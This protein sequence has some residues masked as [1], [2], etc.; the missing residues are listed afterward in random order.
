MMHTRTFSALRLVLL[1]MLTSLQAS[2]AT[3]AAIPFCKS[4]NVQNMAKLCVCTKAL[5]CWQSLLES[6]RQPARSLPQQ[7]KRPC[8]RRVL[9]ACTTRKDSKKVKKYVSNIKLISI[10][11]SYSCK[12]Y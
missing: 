5:M 1:R 9:G 6:L 2:E 8:Y 10:D 3:E 4:Q 12:Y 7:E 11:C